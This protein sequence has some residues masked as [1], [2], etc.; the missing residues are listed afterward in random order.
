MSWWHINKN[1][2]QLLNAPNKFAINI[3]LPMIKR[4]KLS[5]TFAIVLSVSAYH[6][7]YYTIYDTVC[8]YYF[9][10]FH[11]S[12]LCL[13]RPFCQDINT[14][15]NLPRVRKNNHIITAV[16]LFFTV[17]RANLSWM[18]KKNTW[19]IINYRMRGDKLMNDFIEWKSVWF[20]SQ[21]GSKVFT[22]FFPL[23]FLRRSTFFRFRSHHNMNYS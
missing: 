3:S 14:K 4:F 15:W 18:R 5:C 23:E 12:L 2:Y 11:H 1:A 7:L 17:K 19:K 9:F 10:F 8:C 21:F 22:I 13:A 6:I 20:L 16:N